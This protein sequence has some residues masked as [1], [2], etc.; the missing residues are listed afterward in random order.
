MHFLIVTNDAVTED[1]FGR[2][3]AEM[4]AVGDF[5][6]DAASGFS[7]LEQQRFDVVVIDCDDV[8]RGDWLLRNAHKPRPNRSSVVV[9][10]TNGGTNAVDAEDSGADF[11]VAKPLSPDQAR[12]DLQRVCQAVSADQRHNKR[13]PV[14]LPIFLSF[15]QVVD[16]RAEAFNLSLGGIGV[17][18]TEPIE[19]DDIVH[20]R[21][22]LPG[23]VTSIRARGEIAWSDREGNT[24]IKFIG[25]NPE[26]HGLLA[27]WVDRAALR[28]STPADAG[29]LLPSTVASP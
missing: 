3:A 27:D 19:D 9:A 5:R 23:C 7:A 15:G 17:R 13:H 6:G 18:V 16:R 22:W 25:M 21:F 14:Q 2:I 29:N 1:I 12:I 10:I 8:Y 20:V 24:G 4:K 28:V 11:V 26:S